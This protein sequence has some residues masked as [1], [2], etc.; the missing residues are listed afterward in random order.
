MSM[1]NEPALLASYTEVC[2]SYHGISEFRG[3]LLALI[4][5]VSGTG[6]SLLIN[7]P[8]VDSARMVA[9]GAFGMLVTLGLFFYEL[10]GI[11]RCKY[12][13]S[14]GGE[15]ESELEMKWGQ[16]KDRPPRLYGFIGAEIAGWIIYAA[17]LLGWIYVVAIGARSLFR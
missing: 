9:L 12:L 17:V 5:I 10:R 2:K 15:L 11:Q 16:F 8:T 7:R 13:I 14:I 6:I 4:P 3:K 1:N